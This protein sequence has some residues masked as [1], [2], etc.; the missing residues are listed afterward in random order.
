M[1][2]NT[3]TDG[4]L[5]LSSEVRQHLSVLSDQRTVGKV[6][7]LVCVCLVRAREDFGRRV[8]LRRLIRSRMGNAFGN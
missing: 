2:R 4:Y 1:D 5:G 6:I 3:R 8:G 7:C